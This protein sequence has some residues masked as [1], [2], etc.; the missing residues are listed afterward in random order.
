MAPELFDLP[1]ASLILLLGFAAVLLSGATPRQLW[2]PTAAAAGASLVL[3]QV[4]HTG[5]ATGLLLFA[6]GAA[7]GLDQAL[8]ML[9]Q[10]RRRLRK[11]ASRPHARHL[12]ENQGRTTTGQPVKLAGAAVIVST[13]TLHLAVHHVVTAVPADSAAVPVVAVVA[14][15]PV[16]PA[17]FGRLRSV[18]LSRMPAPASRSGVRLLSVSHDPRAGMLLSVV[19]LLATAFA[20]QAT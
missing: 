15:L 14:C 8:A 13:A 12:L 19:V 6:I 3:S 9:R 10:D 16:L 11:L 1:A 18:A 4:A 5:A 20:A 17:V 7:I 2:A